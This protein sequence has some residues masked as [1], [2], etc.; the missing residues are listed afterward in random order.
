VFAKRHEYLS[1]AMFGIIAVKQARA[2]VAAISVWGL[3]RLR[4]D[5][6]AHDTNNKA[7]GQNSNSAFH[8]RSAMF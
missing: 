1:K 5:R 8:K 2:T 7:P 3:W 4:P 6:R